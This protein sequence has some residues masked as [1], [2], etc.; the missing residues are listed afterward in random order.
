MSEKRTV[1]RVQ[2]VG[3]EYSIRSDETPEHTRA[4]A[5]YVDQAIRRVMN[6]GSVVE[7]QRAAILAMLQ[8]TD[9]LFKAREASAELTTGMR[10]LGNEVRRWLPPAKRGEPTG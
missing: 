9:E 5:E 2:I 7:M 4:V 3:E 10:S 8:I 1:V 6:S